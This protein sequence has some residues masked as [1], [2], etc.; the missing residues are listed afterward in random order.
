M[1]KEKS[2]LIEKLD[3]VFSQYIRLRDSNQNGYCRCITCNKIDYW[4]DMQ[5][6]HFIP[7]QHMSTRFDERNCNVQCNTCNVG[8]R[9]NL[10]VYATSLKQKYGDTIVDD[11]TRKKNE[12]VHYS[13]PELKDLIKDYSSKV[14]NLKKEKEV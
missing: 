8:L 14:R 4:K 2:K 10:E 12:T 7:R 5:N 13:I 1:A 3:G 9:G 6:G 11:L